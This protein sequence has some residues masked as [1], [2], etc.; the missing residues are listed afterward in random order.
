MSLTTLKKLLGTTAVVAT[1]ATGALVGTSPAGASTAAAN[2][3]EKSAAEALPADTTPGGPAVLGGAP[4]D[5]RAS[6]QAAITDCDRQVCATFTTSGNTVVRTNFAGNTNG[7]GCARARLVANGVVI[8][9]TR[10]LCY[11]GRIQL[12][13]Y[14]ENDV[15]LAPGDVLR[16]D[17]VGTNRPLGRPGIVRNF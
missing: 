2:A 12:R 4:A 13:G 6:A 5:A 11:A 3:I 14:F 1:L 9:R 16:V 10:Q 17:F 7:P 8:A 15:F